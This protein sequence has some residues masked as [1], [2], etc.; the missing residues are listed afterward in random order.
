MT[1]AKIIESIRWINRHHA[2]DPLDAADISE[3]LERADSR[4]RR[5][6]GDGIFL[7]GISLEGL[8][9]ACDEDAGPAYCWG[10]SANEKRLL[11][12]S[13]STLML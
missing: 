7:G 1:D 10:L 13:Y 3:I 8:S 11:S 2:G 4:H 6:Y 12:R 9:W 5:M